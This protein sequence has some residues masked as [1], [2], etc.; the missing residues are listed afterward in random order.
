MPKEQQSVGNA[1]NHASHRQAAEVGVANVVRSLAPQA[2]PLV[3]QVVRLV[4]FVQAPSF[5]C[6]LLGLERG[7]DARDGACRV[8]KEEQLACDY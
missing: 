1:P 8:N 6:P 5:S 3:M 2:P 7:E 4:G